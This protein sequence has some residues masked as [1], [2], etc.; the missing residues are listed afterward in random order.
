MAHLLAAYYF[1]STYLVDSN[2]IRMVS[3]GVTWCH[4]GVTWCHDGVTW[5]HDGVTMVSHGVCDEIIGGA[6][7]LS[8]YI[9][10][11]QDASSVVISHRSTQ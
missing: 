11:Q 7:Y 3:H 8:D 5:C 4:D 2:Y 10:S 1:A 6:F 9:R